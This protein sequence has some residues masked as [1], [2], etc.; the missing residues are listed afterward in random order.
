[1]AA[2]AGP[3]QDPVANCEVTAENEAAAEPKSPAS[4]VQADAAANIGPGPA[5]ANIS[6]ELISGGN[7][8]KF[9]TT[10]PSAGH[11]HR[12]SRRCLAPTAAKPTKKP[13]AS[14]G[15]RLN[16]GNA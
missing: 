6:A 13:G 8:E 2:D 1:M 7:T 12:A 15:R 10:I 3:C 11:T 16:P 9:I 5:P 14:D 4:P